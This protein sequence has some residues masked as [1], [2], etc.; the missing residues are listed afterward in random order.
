MLGVQVLRSRDQQGIDAVVFEQEAVVRK[1]LATG[2]AFRGAVAMSAVDVA[3]SNN[4][5]VSQ[6]TAST[7]RSAPGAVAD[8]S[9][10]YPVVGSGHRRWNGE[11]APGLE[12]T[13]P[14]NFRRELMFL[15]SQ[16]P[17]SLHSITADVVRVMV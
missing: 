7:A 1:D 4:F 8:D 13:W 14:R 17:D 15:L 10:P 11:S 6:A 16:H 5:G 9:Q 12:A 2:N 3:D